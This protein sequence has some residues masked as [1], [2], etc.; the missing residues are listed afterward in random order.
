MSTRHDEL[1]DACNAFH[2]KHPEVWRLFCRFTLEMLATGRSH[3]GAKAI[4]E[5]VRWET[6][7]GGRSP[8]LKINNNFAA[9]YARRFA[10]LHP[11]HAEF[12]RTREQTSKGVQY[13]GDLGGAKR[14]VDVLRDVFPGSKVRAHRRINNA[15]H[16]E[17]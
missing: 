10:R 12:F 17:E 3:Y 16:R 7:A 8:A 14:A 9:F 15:S 1:R 2:V 13:I 5:R 4:M 6:D 11:D